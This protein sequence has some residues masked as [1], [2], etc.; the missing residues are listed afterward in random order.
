MT[1][2]I[3][4][5]VI[6]KHTQG[7]F[8]HMKRALGAILLPS[9]TG[10]VFEVGCVTQSGQNKGMVYETSFNVGD[11]VNNYGLRSDK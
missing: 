6:L 7:W 3:L 5:I 8:M 1:I 10:V 9:I 4:T 2:V 11:M